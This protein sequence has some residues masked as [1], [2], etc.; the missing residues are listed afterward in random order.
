MF[1]EQKMTS[2][3]EAPNVGDFGESKTRPKRCQ[4]RPGRGQKR[5]RRDQNRP[6]RGRKRLGRGW[7]KTDRNAIFY[8]QKM[9]SLRA[10]EGRIQE[11]AKK[12]PEEARKRPGRGRKSPEARKRP[13][14]AWKRPGKRPG[15]VRNIRKRHQKARNPEFGEKLLE[16][17]CF[18]NRKGR[19]CG[20]SRKGPKEARRGGRGQ[21]RSGRGQEQVR[22]RPEEAGK[23]R[24]R[25]GRGQEKARRGQERPRKARNPE[26][27]DTLSE[28]LCFLNRK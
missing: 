18:M 22:K 8:E 1:Y 11:K 16:T 21:K 17:Q 27:G 14:K 15:R 24:K 6:G 13:G 7:R 3:V 4:M 5:Q 9:T 20:E 2:V 23:A 25:P 19:L 28:T 12:R 10:T 26:F